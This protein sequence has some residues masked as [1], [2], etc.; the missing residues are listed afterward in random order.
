MGKTETH[1]T[2]TKPTLKKVSADQ[3]KLSDKPVGFR[4][5]GHYLGTATRES[6][7]KEG[8]VKTL[9]TMIIEDKKGGNRTKFLADAGLRMALEDALVQK[10]DYFEAVKGAKIE[11]GSGRTM[12]TW[13]IFQFADEN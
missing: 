12:N 5:K 8:E 6:V 3:I 2:E 10:G 11:I 9:H 13:D 4:I 7:D 1:T